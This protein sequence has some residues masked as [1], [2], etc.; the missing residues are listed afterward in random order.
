MYLRSAHPPALLQALVEVASI[1][2]SVVQ[3]EFH[4]FLD[5]MASTQA[6]LQYCRRKGIRFEAHSVLGGKRRV[7]SMQIRHGEHAADQDA[8]KRRVQGAADKDAAKAAGTVNAPSAVQPHQRVEQQ[9]EQGSEKGSHA[10]VRRDGGDSQATGG[11]FAN[12][13]GANTVDSVAAALGWTP[14]HTAQE[15]VRW[16]RVALRNPTGSDHKQT[17]TMDDELTAPNLT[18]PEARADSTVA[19][20][21]K[22]STPERLDELLAAAREP[23]LRC[24]RVKDLSCVLTPFRLYPISEES[25]PLLDSIARIGGG[26]GDVAGGDVGGYH[27]QEVVMGMHERLHGLS[28]PS[29]ETVAHFIAYIQNDRAALLNEADDDDGEEGKGETP[30]LSP[31]QEEGPTT[32][33][34][35]PPVRVETSTFTVIS[36]NQ[37]EGKEG[38]AEGA[39]SAER[40]VIG[41][42]LHLE[43]HRALMGRV[44]VEMMGDNKARWIVA[45]EIPWG[46]KK[47]D[48]EGEQREEENEAW[49][50]LIGQNRCISSA[51]TRLH[52]LLKRMRTVMDQR[53][54]QAKKAG[55]T[56]GSNG[57]H[58]VTSC[59]LVR[60]QVSSAGEVPELVRY[61]VPMPVDVPA[62]GQLEPFFDYISRLEEQPASDVIFHRGALLAGGHVDMCKQVRDGSVRDEFVPTRI[63]HVSLVFY[64]TDNF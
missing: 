48:W 31:A 53:A 3:A 43:K 63:W 58:V 28:D 18:A 49:G 51:V 45:R 2:P 27:H 52:N 46:R 7:Q 5:G 21:L 36:G 41:V 50:K 40:H 20:C 39:G 54:K 62:Y 10:A 42:A 57:T 64:S 33:N 9:S 13:H 6:L 60:V 32:S 37:E 15:L 8:S 19:L 14:G 22:A 29:P 24:D 56:G 17:T 23:D 34:S 55:T 30:S 38:A 61:P 4:A 44:A 35:P 25:N 26:G 1:P 47:E 11:E 16:A 59:K 12:S